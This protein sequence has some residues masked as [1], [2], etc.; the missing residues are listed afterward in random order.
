[1]SAVLC[2][3]VAVRVVEVS[4]GGCLIELAAQ[5]PLGSIGAIEVDLDGSQRSEWFRVSRVDQSARSGRW[6]C[7]TEFL[8]LAVAGRDSLRGAIARLQPLPY[9]EAMPRLA[10]RSSGDPGKSPRPAGKRAGRRNG[11]SRVLHGKS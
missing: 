8:A 3:D 7:G 1:M 11:E 2:T 6:R 10:G 5:L 4:T 9:A